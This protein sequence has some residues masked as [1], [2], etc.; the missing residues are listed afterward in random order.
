MAEA[1]DSDAELLVRVNNISDFFGAVFSRDDLDDWSLVK[2]FGEFLVRI[3]P[4]AEIMG[5]AL[6]ARAY[7][8]L[9][10][11]ELALDELKQCRSRTANRTL[12]PWETE[13][14]D[15]FFAEEVKLLRGDSR[16]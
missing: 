1:L 8:H 11:L 12:E 10:N 7:R 16:D 6:L 15:A 2:D 5:H 3:L 9:G 14:F 13:M 4:D